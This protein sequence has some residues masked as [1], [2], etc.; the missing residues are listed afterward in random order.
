MR[1]SKP[2]KGPKDSDEKTV[3]ATDQG[4]T[5]IE[6]L[7][8]I[9]VIAILAALLLPALASAK[10][11]G[12]TAQ[13]INNLRQI[14]IMGTLYADDNRDTFF[15]CYD[16]RTLYVPNGGQWFANPN[17]HVEYTACDPT[18]S[19]QDNQ[20]WAI[21]YSAYFGNQMRL[22]AD[23]EGIDTVVDQWRDAGDNYPKDFWL[24]SC[25]GICQLLVIPYDGP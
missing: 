16:D 14:A 9:A 25:Y 15:C 21:G 23:P 5:L 22:F 17:S 10:E 8:V 11:D 7:V 3:P 20:Y 13:C 1:C 19:Q 18:G 12:K 4:F 6:L 2:F 24:N